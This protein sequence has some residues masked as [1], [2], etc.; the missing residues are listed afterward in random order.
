M[1]LKNSYIFINVLFAFLLGS[2]TMAVVLTMYEKNKKTRKLPPFIY[3]GLVDYSIETW[4]DDYGGDTAK[5]IVPPKSFAVSTKPIELS[6]KA[7]AKIGIAVLASKYGRKF[8]NQ[9][10]P[11]QVSSIIDGKV[12]KVKG[13][14]NNCCHVCSEIFIQKADAQILRIIRNSNKQ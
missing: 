9:Q 11:F 13:N 6:G 10:K 2:I 14:P 7:A 5:I 3:G 4:L 1:K 8:V 12:W